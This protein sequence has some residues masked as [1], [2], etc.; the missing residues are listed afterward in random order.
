MNYII[1]IIVAGIIS[2]FIPALIELVRSVA[3]RFRN[4]GAILLFGN[5]EIADAKKLFVKEFSCLP[6]CSFINNID[7]TRVFEQIN[8]GSFGRVKA[9]YQSLYYDW[10]EE[11]ECFNRS[12]FVLESGFVA[13]LGP[14]YVELYF[15]LN[16]YEKA[17]GVVNTLVSLKA[18]VKDGPNEIN[19]ISVS[20]SGLELKPLEI[21][22]TAL[23]I[24]KYYNDDFV[25]VDKLIRERLL[26]VQDKGIIL[27]HGLP[28]TGKTTYLRHIV[29]CLKKKV[30]FVS[31]AVACDLMNPEFIDLL[32][33]NPN[34]VL[35]IEDAE[36]IIMDRKFTSNSSV[37]NLLNLS[38]GLLSDCLNVQIICTFNN[39]LEMV[40]NALLRK[41]RLI[42]KYEFGRLDIHKSQQLS[43]HL[44]FD[45]MVTRYMTLAEIA[46]QHEMVFESKQVQVLG[47]RRD[48]VLE[49]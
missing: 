37:S 27:L 34:S 32:I 45:T 20:K 48:A 2:R 7:A 1:I 8:S 42:A 3:R 39:A 25:A 29:G 13:G 17:A 35:V 28:G 31:P 10:K 43:D 41:G 21:N 24:E 19:I 36:N 5:D 44:G 49:N 11:K 14:G 16:D 30:L 23:D 15:G 47:F 22:A 38:D 4:S 9:I 12:V 33:N 40:D 6:C 18:G 46:N 26:K